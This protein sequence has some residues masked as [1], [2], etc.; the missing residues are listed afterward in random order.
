MAAIFYNDYIQQGPSA[1][2]PIE[3]GKQY[4]LTGDVTDFRNIGFNDQTS[5]IKIDP[6]YKIL[7]CNDMNYGGKCVTLQNTNLYTQPMLKSI[8]MEDSISSARILS[9]DENW[10]KKCCA[11]IISENTDERL[12]GDKWIGDFQNCGEVSCSKIINGQPVIMNDCLDWCSR[13]PEKCDGIKVNFCANHP[14]SSLCG[15]IYDKT[16]TIE[17]VASPKNCYPESD[18]QKQD[19]ITTLV[20]T[21]LRPIDCPNVSYTKYTNSVVIKD[22]NFL[23]YSIIF[24]LCILLAL[25]VFVLFDVI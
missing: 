18:C 9:K 7:V 22:S 2:L 19:L 17:G 8:G 10:D 11:G 13:N 5:A 6:K 1:G 24:F 4:T 16:Q 3:G 12:C 25:S 14:S 21:Y 15:C 23:I 20:P